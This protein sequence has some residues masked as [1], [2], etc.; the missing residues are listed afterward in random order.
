MTKM[1]IIE[2][3]PTDTS[4]VPEIR[5][6][7]DAALKSEAIKIKQ[8]ALKEILADDTPEGEERRKRL[9]LNKDGTPVLEEELDPV[10]GPY[11]LTI[12]DVTDEVRK[13]L[14]REQLPNI[15]VKLEWYLPGDHKEFATTTAVSPVVT[16]SK[17]RMWL[18]RVQ[19]AQIES[20]L[21]QL[22][23]SL[24]LDVEVDIDVKPVTDVE[25]YAKTKAQPRSLEKTTESSII[26]SSGA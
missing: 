6:M 13:F 26:L 25:F 23:R 7:N 4:P 21:A 18:F 20:F 3:D 14:G 11:I 24:T 1:D 10:I 8:E 19:E 22:M 16:A 12:R 9:K 2:T 17:T 5:L 15:E